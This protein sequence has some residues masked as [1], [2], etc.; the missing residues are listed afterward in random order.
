MQGQGG[1]SVRMPELLGSGILTTSESLIVL[2]PMN[3]S[4]TLRSTRGDCTTIL[5]R[6]APW[7]SWAPRRSLRR[8][9]TR[10]WV[11]VTG[12]YQV[13]AS[14]SLAINGGPSSIS[15]AVVLDGS[16]LTLNSDTTIGHLTLVNGILAGSA[17][18]TSGDGRIDFR[19]G[20]INLTGAA[21]PERDR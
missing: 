15:N 11:Y 18:L 4:G 21:W 9:T 5:Y 1:A 7:N 13:S 14:G 12:P 2:G 3:F 19:S 17:T 20:T 6:A 10:A 8:S 16:I